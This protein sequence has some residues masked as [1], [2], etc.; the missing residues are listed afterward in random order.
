V[1]NRASRSDVSET[2]RQRRSILIWTQQRRLSEL[3]IVGG[4][5]SF[6]SYCYRGDNIAGLT[7]QRRS[8]HQANAGERCRLLSGAK[9]LSALENPAS[10]EGSPHLVLETGPQ[11]CSCTHCQ[12]ADKRYYQEYWFLHFRSFIKPFRLRPVRLSNCVP[13]SS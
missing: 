7:P 8:R 13:P 4:G 12:H 1:G 5:V 9:R 6:I 10:R 2:L 3:H 11:C